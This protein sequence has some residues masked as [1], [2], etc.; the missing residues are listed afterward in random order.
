MLRPRLVDK[1]KDYNDIKKWAEDMG[2]VFPR[3][4]FLPSVGALV[5]DE[6]GEKYGCGFLFLSNEVPITF[7]EFIYF[8]PKN[9]PKQS[10]EALDHIIKSMEAVAESESSP[11]MIT[12]SPLDSMTRVYKKH[13]WHISGKYRTELIKRI[14]LQGE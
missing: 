13:G 5:E 11:L 9:T 3:A 6:N 14:D 4:E 8:N 10:A 12:Y 1:E 7:L 2:H